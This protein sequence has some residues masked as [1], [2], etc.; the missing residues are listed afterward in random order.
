MII[1]VLIPPSN[2]HHYPVKVCFLVILP[3]ATE[4]LICCMRCFTLFIARMC[5]S[6]PNNCVCPAVSNRPFF[7]AL[8]PPPPAGGVCACL[9]QSF[10][11]LAPPA[12]PGGGGGGGGAREGWSP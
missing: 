5:F 1:L 11:C 2:N 3:V 9:V 6:L 10:R 7:S 8:H 4:F 12:H